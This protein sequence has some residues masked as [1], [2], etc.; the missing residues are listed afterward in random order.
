M[1]DKKGKHIQ[2]RVHKDEEWSGGG[3]FYRFEQNQQ[4]LDLV[5]TCSATNA[6]YLFVFPAFLI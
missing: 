3:G 4:R 2:Q 1:E 6:S 5:A